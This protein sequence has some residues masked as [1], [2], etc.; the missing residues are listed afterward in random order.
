MRKIQN[1]LVVGVAVNSRH[2]S[3]FDSEGVMKDFGKRCQTVGR[4]ARVG[5]DFVDFWVEF[6]VVYAVNNRDVLVSRR[7]GDEN[8]A[9]AGFDVA[10]SVGFLCENT[11]TLKHHVDVLV[12]QRLVRIDRGSDPVRARALYTEALE[13]GVTAARTRLDALDR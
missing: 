11:G 4:A 8:R 1:V 2:E 3:A 10:F 9:G 7:S 13:K 6:G 5:D 12:P